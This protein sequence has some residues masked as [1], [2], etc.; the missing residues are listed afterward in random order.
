MPL[1]KASKEVKVQPKYW[2]Y[3]LQTQVSPLEQTTFTHSRSITKNILPCNWLHNRN[4]Y[5]TLLAIWL[6]RVNVAIFLRVALVPQWH[7]F[8]CAGKANFWYES[9]KEQSLSCK[10]TEPDWYMSQRSLSLVCSKFKL[11]KGKLW[12]RNSLIWHVG[13]KRFKGSSLFCLTHQRLN[14]F[15]FDISSYHFR[16]KIH[17]CSVRTEAA[18]Q[19]F[20]VAM[21]KYSWITST[22]L[23]LSGSSIFLTTWFLSLFQSPWLFK[24]SKDCSIAY[25]K[26]LV[27]NWNCPTKVLK[28]V[29][30][31]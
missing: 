15:Q 27:Q 9:F 24:G 26:F 13:S 28:W 23:Q 6:G 8:I 14:R 4:R 7:S 20:T 25:L 31:R 10:Q 5:T 11:K 16:Y 18:I 2:V 17:Y 21:S 22:S 30:I 3:L 29:K 1:G 19:P 12:S